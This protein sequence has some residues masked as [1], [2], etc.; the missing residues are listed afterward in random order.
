MFYSPL[1]PQILHRPGTQKAVNTCSMNE[2]SQSRKT[3]IMSTYIL[4]SEVGSFPICSGYITDE[5]KWTFSPCIFFSPVQL[6]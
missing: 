5:D 3:L 6:L 1:F 4:F 2:H